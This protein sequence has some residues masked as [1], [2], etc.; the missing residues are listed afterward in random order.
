MQDAQWS[1][2]EN[3]ESYL[4]RSEDIRRQREDSDGE[5]KICTGRR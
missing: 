5:Y 3:S 4:N 1:L 2:L